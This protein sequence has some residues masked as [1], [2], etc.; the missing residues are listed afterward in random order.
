MTLEMATQPTVSRTLATPLAGALAIF[1][2]GMVLVGWALDIGALKSIVSG[3]VAV[4]PNTALTFILT[5]IA[6]L[7]SSR[8]LSPSSSRPAAFVSRLARY[9]ALMAGGIGL[10]TLS[11]YVLGWNAGGMDQW[12]FP[13]PSGAVATSH[14]G[15]MAPDTA[16]C[17]VLLA[18]ALWLAGGSRKTTRTSV[19][20]AIL[21]SL[22]TIVAL[23]GLLAYFSPALRTRGWGGLT[24]MAAQSAFLFAVLGTTI[25]LG[26]WRDALGPRLTQFSSHLWRTVACVGALAIAF[27]LYARSEEEI[28]RVNELRHQSFLLADELRQSGD[29]LTRMA[30]TYVVTGD[31]VYKQHFQD[32]LDIRDGRKP[33]PEDHWR[34]YWDLELGNGPAPRGSQQAI[35]LLELMRQAGFTEEEFGKLAEAKANS[36]GLTL[37]ELEAM[38]L[39]ESTG[40][41]AEANRAR[42]RTMMHDEKYRQA[43][44]AV[45]GPIDDFLALMDERTLAAVHATEYSAAIFRY[46]LAALGLGLTWVLW[47]T[48]V[49]LGDT[50]GGSVDEVSAH[51]ARIGR[52][53]F[54]AQIQVKSG[55]KNSVLGWLSET[56][57]KLNDVDRER[58]QAEDALRTEI[59]VRKVAQ[60]ALARRVQELAQFN[61]AAVGRELRMVELKG[62]VNGL[63]RQL[64]QPPLY[65]MSLLDG[66]VPTTASEV[67]GASSGIPKSPTTNPGSAV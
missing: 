18:A 42:A 25:V 66:A 37:P 32:I 26:S 31:P 23:D 62:Q 46:L 49:A 16:L 65:E 51:I 4:K 17:F 55:L 39:V 1:L 54:S 6:L 33:R 13:E 56:Q 15:R 10:V 21:G 43:K 64:G 45:M 40:P 9:C 38:K 12:L 52:G 30:R 44:A 63:A 60:E 41:E 50:L 2:G 27:A 58:K 47:R 29:D 20:A 14:P 48:Y 53:D 24:M 67:D 57:A 8:R 7:F 11:E 19:A 59:A 5:G 36:D 22:V 34:P 28:A 3:W 35:P 61:S